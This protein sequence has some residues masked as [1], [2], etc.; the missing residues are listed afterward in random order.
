MTEELAKLEHSFHEVIDFAKTY[1]ESLRS[2]KPDDKAFSATE[3][4]Y[5]LLEVENLWQRRIK[6]LVTTTNRNFE[7][8]D[9]DAQAQ[10][11]NYNSKP[12]QKGLEEWFEAREET[13]DLIDEMSESER[14]I[15][16]VHPKYGEMDT[17][18]IVEI[19]LDH[20]KQHLAQL[21]RTVKLVS[22]N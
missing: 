1:P 14:R 4:I 20:D 3:V 13:V 8:I 12:F 9:P 16:G 7:P 21:E 11:N 17:H 5:H 6:M 10:A 18:R 15:I 22:A 19:M 2:V